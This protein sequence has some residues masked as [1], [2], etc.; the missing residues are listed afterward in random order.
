MTAYRL[1]RLFRRAGSGP[2][3]AYQLA[4]RTAPEQVASS[5][6]YA[7]AGALLVATLVLLVG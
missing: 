1:Y 3:Q 7:A 2:C 6:R 5:A 4:Y